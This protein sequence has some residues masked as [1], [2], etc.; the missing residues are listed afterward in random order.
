VLVVAD[1]PLVRDALVA[2]LGASAAGEATSREDLADAV[3]RSDA[4]V[5]L[6]DMGPALEREAELATML[7][8]IVAP[9]IALAP[10]GTR[11]TAL[12]AAGVLGVIPRD[13]AAPALASALRTISAGLCV[14]D[15]AFLDLASSEVSVADESTTLEP[16]SP[17]EAEVV[18]LLAQGLSNK[19]IA[20]QLG[21]SSHTAKFHIAAILGKLGATSRT[22]A[23][24]R[25]LQ[26]G[27]VML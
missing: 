2:R 10:A 3:A 16:L 8:G 18:Q 26:R 24:V 11:A 21:I 7:E 14:V 27:V 4:G 20:D 9:T 22:E 25:A 6:F 17:R 23:V 15:P 5:I 13:V 1:D 19:Q 12:L